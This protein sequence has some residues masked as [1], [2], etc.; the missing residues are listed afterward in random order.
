MY[1]I[2]YAKYLDPSDEILKE[3]KQ[4]QSI[5]QLIE[6][7]VTKLNGS[8]FMV[9]G[10]SLAVDILLQEPISYD[11]FS[12]EFYSNKS[13][14]HANDLA[15][16]IAERIDNVM[17][18]FVFM[19]TIIANKQY[20]IFYLNRKV[21]TI[22]HISEHLKDI[23]VPVQR[24]T[25][26]N[27]TLMMMSPEFILVDVYRTLY[28]PHKVASWR[29][30]V[31]QEKLLYKWLLNRDQ[32]IN[33]I[34]ADEQFKEF[35]IMTTYILD[36][37]KDFECCLI[38]DYAIKQINRDF[39]ITINTVQIITANAVTTINK[40]K[41]LLSIRFPMSQLQ[42][43]THNIDER[44]QKHTIKA[45][46][47]NKTRDIL[48]LFNA[49][50][51]ELIPVNHI[52][53]YMVANPF[54]ISRFLLLDYMNTKVLM[55]RKILMNDYVSFR[56]KS[57]IKQLIYLLNMLRKSDM[58]I[59]Y[60]LVN[61]ASSI[62]CFQLSIDDYIGQYYDDQIFAKEQKQASELKFRDYFPIR[63]KEINGKFRLINN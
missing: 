7:Y 61:P 8:E 59:N 62:K 15:N 10:G 33:T 42:L 36:L 52:H 6:A 48:V 32:I 3:R 40:I 45:S 60:K 1:S 12:Y 26:N 25:Y 28:S 27:N 19:K 34:G 53:G 56:I 11:D 44:L 9:L 35:N 24:K 18:H 31:N 57:I 16:Y 21:C 17:A 54:V 37:L 22:Y 58:Q 43:S 47:L 14:E 55:V 30:A 50:E 41:Q 49:A 29:E 13:F 20:S 51:Y 4:F 46:I 63:H 5:I 2:D 23:L 38:A 39:N